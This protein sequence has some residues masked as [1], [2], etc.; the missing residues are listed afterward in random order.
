MLDRLPPLEVLQDE[1]RLLP[2]TFAKVGAYGVW[3]H[4]R[5]I[6]SHC[7]FAV[8]RHPNEGNS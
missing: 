1:L 6:L 4:S 8:K 5:D 3:G 2:F 7:Y